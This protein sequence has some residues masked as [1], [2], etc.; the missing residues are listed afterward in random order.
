MQKVHQDFN[1]FRSNYTVNSI[2]KHPN[3]NY[4]NNTIYKY[5]YYYEK[6]E[7]LIRLL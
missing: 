4:Y 7:D 1:F 6:R 5:R 3:R 2:A